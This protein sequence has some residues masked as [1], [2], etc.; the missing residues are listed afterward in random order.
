MPRLEASLDMTDATSK[1][2]RSHFCTVDE[3]DA[4][5][6]YL[7]MCELGGDRLL[8]CAEWNDE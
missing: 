1:M 3:H 5:I 6:R 8:L 4:E 7:Q 2:R